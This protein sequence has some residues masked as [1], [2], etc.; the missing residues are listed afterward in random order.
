LVLLILV[1]LFS[2]ASGNDK[3][4]NI[5]NVDAQTVASPAYDSSLAK[6]SVIDPVICNSDRSQ[7][8]ALYLPSYYRSDR[9][10]PCIYFYDAHARGVMPVRL[11]KNIAEKYGFVLI[12]SNVSKNGITWEVTNNTVKILME[13]NRRRINIDA[14]RIYTS[15]FSGGARVASSI[16]ITDGGIAGVIGCAAGFPKLQEAFEHKFDYVGMVGEAD[17]NLT[18]MTQLDEQLEQKGFMHQLLT[19]NG[20]HGWPPATDFETA[21][22][23]MHVNAMKAHLQHTND[24]IVNDLKKA[25]TKRITAAT[26]LINLVTARQLIEGIIRML[27]GLT[28][29]SSYKKQLVE[30]TASAAYKKGVITQQQ[31]E[32]Q[33][34]NTQ[35]EFAKQFPAQTLQ[36]WTDKIAELNKTIHIARSKQVAQ[37]NQ[38]VLNYLGLISYMYSDHALKSDDLV[39]ADNYLK[40]FLTADPANPDCHYLRAVYYVKKRDNANALTELGKATDA[41]YNDLEQLLSETAFYSLQSD[42]R[43]EK[44]RDSVK[45]NLVLNK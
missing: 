12:G 30:L 44:I 31:L 40:I 32:Q 19:Y 35:Q 10:Y 21:L 14:K 7:S 43:F 29:I 3:H 39:N 8:Y 15:G 28:D 42:T 38:R 37:M 36:W 4:E 26:K 6:G 1:S 27:D 22:L 11:Y 33:E 5:G 9:S 17:F 45:E 25:M 18:E 41:G 13:D 24:T 20:K 34:A 23:W 2:C 16:A